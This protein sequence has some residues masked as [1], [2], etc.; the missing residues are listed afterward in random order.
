MGLQ[1]TLASGQ[2]LVFLETP[3]DLPEALHLWPVMPSG[4]FPTFHGSDTD[5]PTC[6]EPVITL[7]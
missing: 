1:T 2:G 6:K 3:E 4:A 5:L 7:G